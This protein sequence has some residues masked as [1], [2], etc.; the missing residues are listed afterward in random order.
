MKGHPFGHV[1]FFTFGLAA[2]APAIAGSLGGTLELAD[3][4]NFFVGGQVVRSEYPGVPLVGGSGPGSI[5]V[6]QMYVLYRIP[7]SV[8]APPIIMVHGSGHTGVTYET[9][10]D[11]REGW[12][13]Y[14]S[15]KGFPVYV[16]DHAGR[17]SSGFDPTVINRARIES[18]PHSIPEIA[19]PTRERAWQSYHLGPA[20]PNFYPGSQFPS[21]AVDHYFSQLV[22]SAETT[23]PGSDSTVKALVALLDRVGPAIVMVHSQSGGYGLDLVR[24]R[25]E[26]MR[27][28]IDIEG[29]CGPLNADDIAKHFTKVPMLAVWGDNTV[30]AS[31]PNSDARRNG[32]AASI[33]AIRGA[34]GAAKFLLLPEAGLR[35]NTHVMM[36]DKNNLEIADLL[37]AWVRE[38]AG[39]GNE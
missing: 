36:M 13:T 25:P 4:G 1:L 9:T 14:F 28:I 39:K 5:T 37:I 30:G 10:P 38:L 7:K 29:S 3:E 35:G 15:R 33:G 27:A 8:N 21:E 16:V 26:K 11:G 6:N 32:C 18:D 22:P 2:L 19:L 12:A 31:G 24:Q 20:Y 17:G 34:G 23:L